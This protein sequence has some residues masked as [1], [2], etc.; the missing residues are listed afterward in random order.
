MK[1]TFLCILD[2]WGLSDQ[3][4]VNAPLLAQ[5]PNFDRILAGVSSTLITYGPDVGLP[6]GQVGNS[7]VGHMNI[8]AGRVV[9]MDLLGI[10][11]AIECGELENKPEV[12]RFI[13]Q[14]KD[15]QHKAHLIGVLSEGGVHAQ[16]SHLIAM[17]QIVSDAGIPVVLH[18][19]SDGRDVAPKSAVGYLDQLM[20]KQPITA[21]IGT[22]SGRYYAMDRDQRW[23][24]IKLAYDAIVKGQGVNACDAYAAINSAYSDGISDEFILPT[25]IGD[26]RGMADGDGVMLLNFRADRARQ[27]MAAI[28]DPQF[29]QFETPNRPNLSV[30]SGM[31]QYS[32]QHDTYMG[33]IF[34][35]PV[36][37]N[38]L[39]HWVAQHGLKQFRIA[40]TEKYPHVTF[41]LNGGQ[42][43]PNEGETRYLAPSPKV[44]TY[45][46]QP[47]MAAGEVSENLCKAIQSRQYALLVVNYANPDMVGHTGDLAA[48]IAA[49]EA[50]DQG[51]GDVLDAVDA[52]DA[53]LLLCAD[54][55]NCDVMIDFDTGQ[56]HTAHTLN[57]VPV[58]LY[59]AP[60]DVILR[61]GGRL[62]DI[63]P[64]LLELMNLKQ[65]KQMTGQPLLQQRLRK[66][67]KAWIYRVAKCTYTHLKLD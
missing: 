18:L 31:A 3:T 14:L 42:E 38:F 63:A 10:D 12:Q 29:D 51:L 27:I 36:L 37:E 45:D 21:R 53:Q 41:F 22:V 64:T 23:D 1:T 48:A 19:L 56:A 66:G 40:E 35:D 67:E 57:P 54:H 61:N 5:T 30:I 44:P 11:A 16:L 17:T 7:E 4:K 46:L 2:G 26:Y 32:V 20:D 8:G 39:G 49:C 15:T 62:A 43:T 13:T 28:G 34:T 60:S 59:N 25:V 65:P 58:A 33:A 50:V 24:R 55:G 52:C 9:E 6:I 47:E